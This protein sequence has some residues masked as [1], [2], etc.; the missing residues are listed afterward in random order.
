[1]KRFSKDYK[2]KWW[3]LIG[4]EWDLIPEIDKT[5]SGDD[6]I[7]SLFGETILLV[8]QAFDLLVIKDGSAYQHFVVTVQELRKSSKNNFYK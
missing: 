1:M 7:S 5:S 4:E 8:G 6:K 2:K 3:S